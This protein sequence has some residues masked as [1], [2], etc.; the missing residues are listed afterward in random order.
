MIY[1]VAFQWPQVTGKI[2][3]LADLPQSVRRGR[4]ARVAAE[5]QAMCAGLRIAR[6]RSACCLG[7][8]IVASAVTPDDKLRR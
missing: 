4:Q 2:R 8:Q 1:P 3:P 7:S 6:A 5:I